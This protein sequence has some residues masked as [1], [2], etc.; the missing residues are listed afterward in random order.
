MKL[1]QNIFNAGSLPA[2]TSLHQLVDV[3]KSDECDCPEE[4]WII[5]M[6]YVTIH[7]EKDGGGHIFLDCGDWD[8]E[9]LVECSCIE[10]LR[11]KAVDWVNSFKVNTNM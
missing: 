1:F 11:I 4:D 3:R 9:K 10:E 5:G 8:D 2:M 6:L 7:M